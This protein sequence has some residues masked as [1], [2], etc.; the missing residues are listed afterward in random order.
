MPEAHSLQFVKSTLAGR[1]GQFPSLLAAAAVSQTVGCGIDP[2]PDLGSP[3][4][5]PLRFG[6]RA[7]VTGGQPG[8]PQPFS[9][10]P[11][12]LT[13]LLTPHSGFRGLSPSLFPSLD[14]LAVVLR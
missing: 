12:A 3:A 2:S 7:G 11:D 9:L 1:A 6:E 5:G 8:G 14:L 4:S 10:F 13:H